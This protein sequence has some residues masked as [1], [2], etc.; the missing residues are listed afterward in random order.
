MS[1]R[2]DLQYQQAEAQFINA[3]PVM[4]HCCNNLPSPDIDLNYKTQ[5][6]PG[7]P[8]REKYKKKGPIVAGEQ[9]SV[10][11]EDKSIS[12][13][14]CLCARLQVVFPSSFGLKYK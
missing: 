8:V 10:G 1:R 4:K 6:E 5:R 11:L 9:K 13:S 2:W 3:E 7:L 12:K 14:T